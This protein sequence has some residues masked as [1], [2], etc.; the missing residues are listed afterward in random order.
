MIAELNKELVAA[1]HAV[2][3]EL[4]VVDPESQRTYFLVNSDTYRQAME[5]LRSQQDRE[6]IA[7]GLL[8]MQAGEGK[9]LDQAFSDLRSRLG[10]SQA[11]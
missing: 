8:Q 11:K 2:G 6:A 1:L 10:F 4:E 3:G 7:E 5:A 9:P